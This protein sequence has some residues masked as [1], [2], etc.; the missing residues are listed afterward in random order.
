MAGRGTS[1]V[2]NWLRALGTLAHAECGGVGV[3]AIGMCLTGNFALAMLIEPALVAAVAC[4]PS[5]PLDNPAAIELSDDEAQHIAARLE[6][7]QIPVQAYRFEGD[8]FCRAARF[9]TYREKRGPHLALRVLP[10]SAANPNPSPFFAE[11]IR[12]P[13]SVV[14]QHLID[15][16]GEPTLTARDEMIAYLHARLDVRAP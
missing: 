12:S 14:T 2:V 3:G 4:Q 11:H 5:L 10:G 7:E 6:R 8:K 16:D 15:R 1:P 9:E 13:H